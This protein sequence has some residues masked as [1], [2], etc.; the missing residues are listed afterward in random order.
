MFKDSYTASHHSSS[1]SAFVLLFPPPTRSHLSKWAAIGGIPQT[2]LRSAYVM[3]P[4]LH[5]ALVGEDVGET[6]QGVAVPAS[7]D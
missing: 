3:E 5:W 7:V 1:F 2:H 4:C 6:F